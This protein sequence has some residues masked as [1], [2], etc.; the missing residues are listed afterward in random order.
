VFY[1]AHLSTDQFAEK[2]IKKLI[3]LIK[4]ELVAFFNAKSFFSGKSVAN[5]G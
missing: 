2:R 4:T 3:S 1:N 5:P